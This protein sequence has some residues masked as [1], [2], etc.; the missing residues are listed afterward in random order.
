MSENAAAIVTEVIRQ[1][2]TE[3][4]LCD[5][6]KHTPLLTEN[7]AAHR[8]SVLESIETAGWAPFHFARHPDGIA[9]PWRAHVVWPEDLKKLAVF[10]QDD[11]GLTSNEPRLVAGCSVLVLVTWLPEFDDAVVAARSG[12]N[13]EKRR[14]RDE[15]HLAAASAM[16]QNLLLMLTA[17]GMGTYWSSG[18]RLRGAEVFDYLKIPADERLLAAVFIECPETTADSKQRKPGAHRNKRSDAWIREVELP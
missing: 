6:D 18:G 9:E 11:L 5:V 7:A 8:R 2:K 4:V 12:L 3:K 15:E 10:L 17:H 13:A 1:R 16:V 14:T